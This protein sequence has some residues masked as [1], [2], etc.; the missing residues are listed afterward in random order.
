[1]SYGLSYHVQVYHLLLVR[2][3]ISI[4]A[5]FQGPGKLDF[6]SLGPVEGSESVAV[7][8]F[9]LSAKMFHSSKHALTRRSYCWRGY[10]QSINSCREYSSSCRQCHDCFD[11]FTS[12]VLADYSLSCCAVACVHDEHPPIAEERRRSWIIRDMADQG[13]IQRDAWTFDIKIR[14]G[15]LV[16]G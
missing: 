8:T 13:R 7:A 10:L 11:C 12:D 2:S 5:R 15:I 3:T 9:Y 4:D 6:L 14:D 16:K 1:M